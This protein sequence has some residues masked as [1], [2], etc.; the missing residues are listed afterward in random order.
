MVRILSSK[1]ETDSQYGGIL[2]FLHLLSFYPGTAARNLLSAIT[3]TD[4]YRSHP[5]DLPPLS[6]RNAKAASP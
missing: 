1:N 2:L 6:H 3:E 5:Q 4:T